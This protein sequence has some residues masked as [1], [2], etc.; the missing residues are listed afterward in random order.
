MQTIEKLFTRIRERREALGLNQ[1][2][3]AD[4]IGTNQRQVSQWELGKARPRADFVIALADALK[5]TPNYLLGFTDDPA[6]G[7]APAKLTA[8]EQELLDTYRNLPSRQRE[9]MRFVRF[10][11]HP[12]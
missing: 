4:M 10:I 11:S 12:E 5:T 3:L 8:E 2:A 6:P 7:A 1:D 9:L